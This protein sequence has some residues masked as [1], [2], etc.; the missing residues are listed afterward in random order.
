MSETKP[1]D[2]GG[3]AF[4]VHPQQGDLN[5]SGMSLR[6]WFAAHAPMWSESERK[7]RI[8]RDHHIT[9]NDQQH[10]RRDRNVVELEA[11]CRYQWADAMISARKENGGK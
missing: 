3:Y 9:M 11:E 6:D 7:F 2:D 5:F 10:M 1:I 4:P 8:E